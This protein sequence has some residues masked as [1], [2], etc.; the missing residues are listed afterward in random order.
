MDHVYWE[1]AKSVETAN[2]YNIDEE[3]DSIYETPFRE[4]TATLVFAASQASDWRDAIELSPK[5]LD[6]IEH[7]LVMN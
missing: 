6:G 4:T 5:P 7:P 3:A 1:E 2:D